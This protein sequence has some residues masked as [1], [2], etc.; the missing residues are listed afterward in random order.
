[1]AN[2]GPYHL[3][4]TCLPFCCLFLTDLPVCNNGYVLIK[5]WKSPLHKP[6]GGGGRVWRWC[7]IYVTRASSWYW[8]TVGQSLVAGNAFISSVSFSFLFLFLPCSSLSSPATISFISFLPF[9]GRRHN[10]THK[11]EI[12]YRYFIFYSWSRHEHLGEPVTLYLPLV[13]HSKQHSQLRQGRLPTECR[14]REWNKYTT[15]GLLQVGTR[16]EQVILTRCR[17][18][19]AR[20]PF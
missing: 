8:L 13:Y 20:Y 6:R 16:W 4:L 17:I 1:M 9:S 18:G 19:H 15:L 2:N 7:V 10:M 3:D 14:Q 5:T 11:G 12:S